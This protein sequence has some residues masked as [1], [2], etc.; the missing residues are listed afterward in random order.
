MKA[1]K[2][3][4]SYGKKGTISNAKTAFKTATKAASKAIRGKTAPKNGPSKVAYKASKKV[5]QD[6]ILRRKMK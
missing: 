5:Y 2:A 3:S 4:T 1:V 6:E